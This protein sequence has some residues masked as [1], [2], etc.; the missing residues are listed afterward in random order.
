MGGVMSG[1]LTIRIAQGLPSC[2][3][4]QHAVVNHAQ[5]LDH[6]IRRDPVYQ[7]VSR[8]RD[9]VVSRGQSP[10]G[11]EMECLSI[12]LPDCSLYIWRFS[13][14]A[15]VRLPARAALVHRRHRPGPSARAGRS[16]RDGRA[17]PARSKPAGSWQHCVAGTPSTSGQSKAASSAMMAN[18]SGESSCNASVSSAAQGGTAARPRAQVLTW[19]VVMPVRRRTRPDGRRSGPAGRRARYAGV[20]A[21]RFAIELSSMADA[22]RVVPH[23]PKRDN[24]ASISLIAGSTSSRHIPK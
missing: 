18:R 7:Q 19:R 23:R 5:D 12:C 9:V 6:T 13:A 1:S 20:L 11:S 21:W 4:E 14:D 2:P 15:G 3:G 8:L 22:H 17:E 16:C 24:T 10:R